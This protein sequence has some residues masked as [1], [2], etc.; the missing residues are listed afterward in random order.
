MRPNSFLSINKR[1]FI[2]LLAGLL[3]LHGITS[4]VISQKF[5]RPEGQRMPSDDLETIALWVDQVK[6][7][8]GY[9]VVILG[10]SVIHGQAVANG[11]ETLPAYIAEELRERLPDRD[12]HVFNLGMPGGAPAEVYFMLD[13]LAGSGVDLFIYNINMAWFARENTLDHPAVT[14]LKGAPHAFDLPGLG[15]QP[16]ESNRT[17]AEEWFAQHVLSHW[18]PYRYRILINYW[19]WGKP[20]REKIE[21]AKKDS[22]LLLPFA[23]EKLPETLEMRSPWRQKDWNGKLDPNEG[24]VGAFYLTGENKQWVFYRMLL[25]AADRESIPLVLFITPRNYELLERYDMIDRPA[26]SKNLSVILSATGAAGFPVLDYDS[27]IPFETFSDIVHLLP[28]GN[29]ILARQI[30]LDL[31]AKGYIKR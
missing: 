13:A 3:A 19:L 4:I 24:R 26:Y 18:Q 30:A 16:E 21:D 1:A 8:S 14:R 28:E 22:R 12:V 25:D 11:M 15:I 20:L 7:C 5:S 6:K 17:P 10:D 29:K 9:K 31:F 23:E 27:S 2:F